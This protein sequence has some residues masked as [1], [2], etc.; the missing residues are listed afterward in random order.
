MTRKF[1]KP[2]YTA[3]QNIQISLGEA[4]SAN[5]LARFVVD[6]VAKLDLSAIYK[7]YGVH[8]G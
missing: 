3:T 1:T 8:G 6:M 4:I 2:D 7:S 5:Q